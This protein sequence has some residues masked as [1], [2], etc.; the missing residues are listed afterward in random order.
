MAGTV[1]HRRGGADTVVRVRLLFVHVQGG[2]AGPGL[3]VVWIVAVVLVLE[4]AL[5]LSLGQ[6]HVACKTR[7][8]TVP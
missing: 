6:A 7:E 2:R 3:C 1:S 4:V 8:C 5:E